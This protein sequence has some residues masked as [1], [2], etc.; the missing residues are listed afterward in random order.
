MEFTERELT[1]AYAFWYLSYSEKFSDENVRIFQQIKWNVRLREARKALFLSARTVAER[2]QISQSAY[3]R[4]EFRESRG[5]ITLDLLREAADAM[6]C[7]L[8]YGIR[9]R[10]QPD[11]SRRVWQDVLPESKNHPALKTCNQVHRALALAAAARE[12]SINA[13]FRRRHE[14]SQLRPSPG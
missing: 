1:T 10:G 2:L 5:K 12:N 7:E 13:D 11:F 9:P 8:I 4:L 6:D 14:W 3:S